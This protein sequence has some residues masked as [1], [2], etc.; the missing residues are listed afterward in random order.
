[1][2]LEEK[3]R[4]E[5]LRELAEAKEKVGE[6]EKEKEK[7]REAEE[8]SKEE[9]REISQEEEGENAPSSSIAGTE[10]GRLEKEAQKNKENVK[11]EL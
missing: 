8:I 2:F 9:E 3:K 7:E 6:E 1:L 11:S 5:K 4:R 10:F